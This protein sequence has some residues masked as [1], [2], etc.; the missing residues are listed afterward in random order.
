MLALHK[1]R[2]AAEMLNQT[3]FCLKSKLF[4]NWVVINETKEKYISKNTTLAL[5]YF[6]F[7]C[8]K[9]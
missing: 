5:V 3:K 6:V 7:F 2:I 4:A 1:P 9:P 8:L